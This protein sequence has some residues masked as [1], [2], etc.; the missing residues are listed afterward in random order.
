[1]RFER[2]HRLL[3]VESLHTTSRLA[4]DRDVRGDGQVA[5][6]ESK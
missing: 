6:V 5:A 2:A 3:A 1:V 4:K